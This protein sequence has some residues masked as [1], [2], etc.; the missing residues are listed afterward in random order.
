MFTTRLT[1]HT[2]L[3]G[4]GPVFLAVLAALATGA[5]TLDNTTMLQ[6]TPEG[7]APSIRDSAR[8]KIV[9]AFPRDSYGPGE[10]AALRILSAAQDV[11]LQVFRVGPEKNPTR[12]K[13]VMS[14]VP[15]SAERSLG[16]V[17][18]KRVANVRIGNWPSGVYFVRLR[19]ERDKLGFAPFVVRPRRLGEH[20]VAIVM[21]TQTWQAYN[22][23]DD[24]ADGDSDTWY[25]S[26]S[27]ARLGRAHLQR[28]VPFRFR[29]YDAPFLRW[30][31]RTGHQA[32]Y[33]T[34]DELDRTTGRQLAAA[35]SLMIFPGHHEYVTEREYNAVTGFR[36][37]GGNLMFLSANNFY[38]KIEKRGRLMR[39]VVKWRDI[40][41]P[42]AAFIGT[43]YFYNDN[44]ERRG[45]WV[46]RTE[47]PWLFA[48][49]GLRKGSKFSSG[50]IEADRVYPSSPR[51]VRVVAEIPNIFPGRG[52]A[53]MTYY[54]RGGAKV[55]A[56]GAF[57]MAGAI[58]EKP[59]RQMVANLWQRLANDT[60]TGARRL[61]GRDDD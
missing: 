3:T 57:T 8:P 60:D 49:T 37:R 30:A 53:Q 46:L 28:G 40:G 13:D 21:P 23:R 34:D 18:P 43:Q 15:V 4:R 50:G 55:F 7:R 45:R 48:G 11:H 54:E 42:E 14:G 38:W 2:R 22:H 58:G 35:Y 39:R 47:I 24:D 32:D 29:N 17:T 52:S 10:R 9:A 1:S 36:N 25:A 19:G 20:R 51:S 12:A 31:A 59:I 33:L 56:A 26:G 16:A 61:P 27:L 5:L 41:R 6:S 44:G